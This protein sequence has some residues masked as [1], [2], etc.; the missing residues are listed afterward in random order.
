MEL[1]KLKTSVNWNNRSSATSLLEA[2]K[3]I[4]Q[5]GADIGWERTF[6]LMPRD[7]NH[8]W[9][10]SFASYL[11]AVYNRD[12]TPKRFSIFR[13]VMNVDKSIIISLFSLMD[14]HDFQITSVIG[15]GG[16][17]VLGPYDLDC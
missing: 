7:D 16:R 2:E 9:W 14:Y 3:E 1:H 10:M 17:P 8:H 4:R 5:N 15:G 11:T 6:D 13:M 12:H